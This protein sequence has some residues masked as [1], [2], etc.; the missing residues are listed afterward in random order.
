MQPKNDA[1][2]LRGLKELVEILNH[3]LATE[4]PLDGSLPLHLSRALTLRESC[5]HRMAELAEA[6][7]EDF[8]NDRLIAAFIMCRAIMETESLFWALIDEL[9]RAIQMQN[10]DQILLFLKK[11]LTGVK[12]IELKGLKRG[13]NTTLVIDDPTNVLTFI[14][15]MQKKIALYRFHYDALSERAHPNSAGTIDAY[16]LLDWNAQIARFGKNR[17]RI[18][19]KLALPHLVSSLKGF[20]KIYDRSAELLQQFVHLCKELPPIS[21]SD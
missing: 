14:D 9:N 20:L 11:A 10:T 16:V 17:S 4:M 15:K 5:F 13:N 7:Y 6:A 19:P 8:A 1:T 2:L 21:S 18:T 12:S 3:S